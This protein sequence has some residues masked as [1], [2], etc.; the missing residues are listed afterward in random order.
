M[1]VALHPA[2]VV[3]V[4]AAPTDPVVGRAINPIAFCTVSEVHVMALSAPP[5]PDCHL[6]VVRTPHQA[7]TANL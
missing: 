1:H 4:A 2:P 6:D 5:V 7:T 3:P